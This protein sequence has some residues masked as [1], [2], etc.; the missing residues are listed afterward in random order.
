MPFSVR[1]EDGIVV[2]TCS[3]KLVVEDAKAGAMAVWNDPDFRGKPVVWDFRLAQLDVDAAG[4]REIAQFILTSQPDP[5]PKVALVT[6]REVDFGMARMLEAYRENPATEVQVFRDY[7]A[8]S[9]WVKAL[10]ERS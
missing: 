10:L 6:A 9:S 2:G 4:V 3:G 7:E 8:A 5:P 1:L